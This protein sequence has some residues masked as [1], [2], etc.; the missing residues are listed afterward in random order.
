MTHYFTDN[1]GLESDPIRFTYYFDNE[2]FH[3]TGDRGVFSKDKIDYGS[4][5]L[6]KNVYRRELGACILDL[7][8]GYG[9]I[10]IILKRF[11]PQA[12]TVL[13][14]VNPRAVELAKKNALDNDTAVEAA[15][16]DDITS[17]PDTFDSIICNPP[18]RAGK[19]LIFSLYSKAHLKLRECGDL[20]IVVQ[21]KQGARSHI[22]YL[23]TFFTEVDV[24]DKDGGYYVI[25]A[26]K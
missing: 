15:V 3:F 4:Y 26:H 7:G 23:Q 21:K 25:Q 5:V 18:I 9:P 22:S 2:V 17:L 12:K 1:S 11:H 20:Y 19:D 10:G 6:I 16:C 8:C 14:D 13:V 24:L